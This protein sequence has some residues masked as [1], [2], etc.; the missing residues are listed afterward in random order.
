[1]QCL[2]VCRL[3]TGTSKIKMGLLQ[4]SCT[5]VSLQQYIGYVIPKTMRKLELFYENSSNVYRYLFK[6]KFNYCIWINIRLGYDFVWITVKSGWA[7]GTRFGRW[8]R[9]ALK[10]HAYQWRHHCTDRFWELWFVVRRLIPLLAKD[11]QSPWRTM[12]ETKQ[13]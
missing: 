12:R 4:F 11:R 10:K 5:I 6:K 2:F 9:K 13:H 3:N 1:M 8:V 7:R